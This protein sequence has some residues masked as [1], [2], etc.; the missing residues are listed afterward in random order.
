MDYLKQMIQFICT[1]DEKADRENMELLADGIYDR[2]LALH[3]AYQKKMNFEEMELRKTAKLKEEETK[4]PKKDKKKDKKDKKE[5]KDKNKKPLKEEEAKPV[6]DKPKL[7][8]ES[9]S[10]MTYSERQS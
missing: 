1:G 9:G 10:R 7:I 3:N 8:Q 5:K 4:G 6:D 2:A